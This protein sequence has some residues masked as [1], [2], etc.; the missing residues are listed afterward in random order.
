MAGDNA[1]AATKR[2]TCFR[3]PQNVGQRLR[4][5][6]FVDLATHRSIA[7]VAKSLLFGFVDAAVAE[8]LLNHTSEHLF[9]TR[10]QKTWL[11]A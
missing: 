7:L 10:S 1:P 8:T 6:L 4:S 5:K 11:A 3:T 9:E 2:N